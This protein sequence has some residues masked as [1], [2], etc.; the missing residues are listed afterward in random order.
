LKKR[1]SNIA[2]FHSGVYEKP[3]IE[4]D[5]LYLQAVHFSKHGLLDNTVQPQLRIN[6]KLE[7]HLLQ[8]DDL[9]FAA[10]G[11]NN[12]A[13][14]YHQSMGKAVASSSFL[15]IR[16]HDGVR[17]LI[18]PDYLAW[19]ISHDKRIRLLHQQQLGT[20]IPSINMKQLAELEIDIPSLSMQEKI[21]AVQQLRD[22]ERELNAQLEEWRDRQIQQ[23]LSKAANK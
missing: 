11:L 18:H 1:L 22:R 8:D 20:T 21:V 13:V 3:A 19:F 4:P 10:K 15:I 16:I 12:F 6:G 23:L 7:K 17:R 5:T 2:Q 9:L 14:V